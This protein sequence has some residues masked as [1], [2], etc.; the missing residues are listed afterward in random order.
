MAAAN[1]RRSC[2]GIVI[3]SSDASSVAEV[4]ASRF[5]AALSGVPY[6]APMT[7]PCSVMRMRADGVEGGSAPASHRAAAPV[8][9]LHARA[10][11]LEDLRQ[12]TRTFVQTPHRS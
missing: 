5:T 9:H 11:C 4:M 7:S 3:F 6:L 2:V 12:Q 1:W 10:G 8:K